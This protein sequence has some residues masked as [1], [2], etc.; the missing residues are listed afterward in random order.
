M[1]TNLYEQYKKEVV[2]ALQKKLGYKSV[3]QAPKISKVVLNVGVGRFVKEP[4]YID[5][6]ERTLTAITGQKPMRSKAKKAISNFKIRQGMEIGV[7]VTLRGTR[8]Y[9][10]LEKL[11]KVTFPRTR[12]FRGISE[13]SFD[14]RGNYTMGFKENMA[15]PEIK[16][17]EIDKMHGLQIIINT[18]AKSRE[19]GQA[20]L[21]AF[22]FPL[23]K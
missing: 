6:V 12:D 17:T 21:A 13:K 4:S 10:F 14:T 16:A 3:M 7:T 1:K 22:G 23:V 2:P 19:E 18:T 5:N 9:Q 8:M 20:L 11:L 15:F